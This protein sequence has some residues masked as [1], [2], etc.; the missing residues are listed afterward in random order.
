VQAGNSGASSGKGANLEGLT[1]G[2]IAG[3]E[4]RVHY[5]WFAI[6]FLLI[7]WLA[8]GFFGEVYDSWS[9]TEAWAAAIAATILFFASV[10]L[11]EL[12][13][14]LTA[15]RLGLPVSSITLFIFGG[16]SSLTSEPASAKQE[17]QIAIVGPGTSFGLAALFGLLAGVALVSDSE[18]SPPGAVA[19]YLAIINVALGVFNLLPGFPLDGGRVLRAAVWSRSGDLVTAT[20][21]AS[22]G[23]LAISFGLIAIGVVSILGGNF[24]GGAWMVVIGWFLRGA[25]QSSYEQLVVRRT[26]EGVRVRDVLDRSF[27]SVAPDDSLEQVVRRMLQTSQ[28]CVPVLVGDDLLGLISIR[29]LK[30]VPEEEWPQTSAFRAMTPREKLHATSPDEDLGRVLE[31]MAANDVHQLPVLDGKSFVGFVTR[32][33][34]LRLLQVRSELR[35][36]G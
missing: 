23:G 2:R 7:W 22:R 6:F 35:E 32:A 19:E 28:R 5:S 31:V 27:V 21:W 1:L 8:E 18:N 29:D 24:I 9:A 17:F 15:K 26:L 3:I 10:L 33:D 14:S 4:I 25:A 16:V 12:A 13:H 36:A 11:H 34:V 30:R 20:R